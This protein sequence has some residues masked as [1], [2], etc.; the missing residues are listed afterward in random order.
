MNTAMRELPHFHSGKS[1]QN[2]PGIASHEE[3][4]IILKSESVL[5][6]EQMRELA[7]VSIIKD[8]AQQIAQGKRSVDVPPYKGDALKR[9]QIGQ[10]APPEK[11]SALVQQ[12]TSTPRYH[13]GTAPRTYDATLMMP[14][15][16]E[17]TAPRTYDATLMMPRYHEGTGSEVSPL[18]TVLSASLPSAAVDS[19]GAQASLPSV[20]LPGI[21]AAPQALQGIATSAES[22][23]KQLA[24]VNT[25]PATQSMARL[26]ASTQSAA[27]MLALFGAGS[28]FGSRNS[29]SA[30][31]GSSG[32]IGQFNAA[33]SGLWAGL[34]IGKSASS[35]AAPTSFAGSGAVPAITSP[36]MLEAA[37]IATELASYGASYP[38]YMWH[39]GGAPG[40]APALREMPRFHGGADKLKADEQMAVLLKSE[41]VLTEKQMRELAPVTV[42]AEYAARIAQTAPPSRPSSSLTRG[43]QKALAPVTALHT[44][45]QRVAAAQNS[46]KSLPDLALRAPQAMAHAPL[47][48]GAA[49]R[50]GGVLNNILGGQTNNVIHIKDLP[51]LHGGTGPGERAATIRDTD[52]VLTRTVPMGNA[53]D[54]ARIDLALAAQRNDGAMNSSNGSGAVVVHNNFTI[55][56]ATDRRSQ[57]QIAAAAEQGLYRA[58]MRGM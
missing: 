28:L 27:T 50:A 2:I 3:L 5:T 41:S 9:G 24:A 38:F 22:A 39:N 32:A 30:G 49:A 25:E 10:L 56:G 43:Q 11:L 6:R 31:S 33:A 19:I 53:A 1:S 29:G 48:P 13:E 44:A 46:P 8:V 18:P 21:S 15:Y 20:A 12:A 17:G 57:L 40:D 16:H 34:G 26:S 14:R 42:L 55:S 54:V 37:P 58:R 36:A 4:A 51:R 52:S 47:L 23:S 45:M 35:V 7:P